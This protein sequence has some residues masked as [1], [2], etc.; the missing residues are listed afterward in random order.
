MYLPLIFKMSGIGFFIHFTGVIFSLIKVSGRLM[1]TSSTL[2]DKGVTRWDKVKRVPV[3]H[4]TKAV[5][6]AHPF[7]SH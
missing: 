6:G 4:S 3:H 2:W 5:G 1:F 7:L